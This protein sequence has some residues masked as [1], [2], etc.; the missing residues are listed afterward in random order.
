[1]EEIN[2]IYQS[3]N[4]ADSYR[5][6]RAY[7]ERMGYSY[8]V[9]IIHK[10]MNTELNLHSIVRPKKPGTKPPWKGTSIR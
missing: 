7:L 10:Y 2:D 3:H 4:S 5:S 9:A 1:M 6:M 8:S